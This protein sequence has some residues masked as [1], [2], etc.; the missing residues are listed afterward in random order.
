MPVPTFVVHNGLDMS[1][2][3]PAQTRRKQILVAGRAAP[4]K[5]VVEAAKALRQTLP[6][7]PGWTGLFMLTEVDRHPAY[8]AELLK[9]VADCNGAIQ[10]VTNQ[11]HLA[12]KKAT[13][14]SEIA[15]VLS[16]WREPFGRTAIEAHAGGAALI[17]SGSGGLREVS[18]DTCLYVDPDDEK[19]LSEA[20][21]KLG[22]D[23]R[24]RRDLAAAAL[25]RTLQNFGIRKV[26]GR[27]DEGYERYWG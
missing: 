18:A 17:S 5:G 4:E 20:I 13:E 21:M 2:W 26:S 14:E 11:P 9:V 27:L 24:F 19:A 15:L 3:N 23:D 16:K 6:Q 7:L 12:V 10:I 8:Y 22:S 1:Q 25:E